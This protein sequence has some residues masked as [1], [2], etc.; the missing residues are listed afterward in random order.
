MSFP[1]MRPQEEPSVPGSLLKPVPGGGGAARPALGR[2]LHFHSIRTKL[3]LLVGGF[4][5]I[6]LLH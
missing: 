5:I 3:L 4:A 2:L 1:A 6:K